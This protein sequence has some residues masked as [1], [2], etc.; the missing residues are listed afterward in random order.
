VNKSFSLP[1][2]AGFYAVYAY[3]FGEGGVAK[4]F[5]AGA[6]GNIA[7]ETK[8]SQGKYFYARLQ[9]SYGFLNSGELFITPSIGIGF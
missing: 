3:F 1:I 8:F 9:A 5:N 4:G 7:V 2:S 6:G